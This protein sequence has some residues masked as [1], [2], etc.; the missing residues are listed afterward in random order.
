VS[1][2]VWLA[3]SLSNTQASLEEARSW[4]LYWIRESMIPTLLL[5]LGAQ[6]LSGYHSN[7]LWFRLALCSI[8]FGYPCE[9]LFEVKLKCRETYQCC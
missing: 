4:M 2:G 9:F 5:R 1:F 7:H 6:G 3:G 8:Y